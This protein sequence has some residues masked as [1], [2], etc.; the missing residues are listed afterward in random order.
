M[1]ALPF[2]VAAITTRIGKSEIETAVTV[3][4]FVAYIIQV[5]LAKD[6]CRTS[7]S[8]CAYCPLVHN[9]LF[10]VVLAPGLVGVEL[11]LL[12]EDHLRRL[13]HEIDTCKMQPLI[14]QFCPGSN[15]MYAVSRPP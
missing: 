3:V 2:Y 8:E 12:M 1:H 6:M 9:D 15:H 7:I 4:I 5:K 10:K 11:H 14:I 13:A